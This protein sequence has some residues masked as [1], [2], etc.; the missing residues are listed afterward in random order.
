MTRQAVAF[1]VDPC[2]T[3]TST[4]RAIEATD[5]CSNLARLTGEAP[6]AFVQFDGGQGRVL[7]A[8][9]IFQAVARLTLQIR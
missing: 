4:R 5:A 3:P 6:T 9:A 8:G 1:A 7:R 2:I